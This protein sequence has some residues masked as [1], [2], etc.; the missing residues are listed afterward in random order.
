MFAS[1]LRRAICEKTWTRIPYACHAARGFAIGLSPPTLGIYHD[2][3]SRG[4]CSLTPLSW[5]PTISSVGRSPSS[6][7]RDVRVAERARRPV[8]A[9][10][11]LRRARADAR[12]AHAHTQKHTNTQTHKHTNTTR[13]TTRPSAFTKR[14]E[15]A[16]DSSPSGTCCSEAC[17]MSN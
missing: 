12:N 2:A 13:A 5:T 16:D 9:G 14:L 8:P 6:R 11:A 7:C 15:L 4:A 1:A 10:R 3:L 17:S